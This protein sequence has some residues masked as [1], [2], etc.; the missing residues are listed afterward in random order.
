MSH[1]EPQSR[2]FLSVIGKCGPDCVRREGLKALEGPGR[3][4]PQFRVKKPRLREGRE[5]TQGR[6]GSQL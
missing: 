5:L 1:S 2:E 6:A 3:P 4:I